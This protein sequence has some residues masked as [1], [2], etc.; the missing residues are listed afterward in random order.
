MGTRHMGQLAPGKRV[1]HVLQIKCPLLH[2]MMGAEQALMH[3]GHVR[4]SSI[5]T[6]FVVV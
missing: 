3:T 2:P 6:M 5:F 4:S 1:M